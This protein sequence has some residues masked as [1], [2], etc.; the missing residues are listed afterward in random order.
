MGALA[1]TGCCVGAPGREV[2]PSAAVRTP[3]EEAPPPA[4]VPLRQHLFAAPQALPDQPQ[5][6][7]R[8][9]DFSGYFSLT[10]TGVGT[11]QLATSM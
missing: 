3:A 11:E 5:S 4:P 8:G 1:R 10:R 6:W 7:V 2:K 9:P